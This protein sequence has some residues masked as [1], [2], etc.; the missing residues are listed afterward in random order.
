VGHG[1]ARR[2]TAGGG[3]KE[4][5]TEKR[6]R[7]LRR[8]LATYVLL[9]LLSAAALFGIFVLGPALVGAAEQSAAQEALVLEWD[10]RLTELNVTHTAAAD[11]SAGCWRLISARYESPEESGGLH[12][13]FLI[14]LDEQGNQLAGQPWTVA[15]PEGSVALQTKPAPDWADFPMYASYAPDRGEAG[16]YRAFVGTDEAR[17]DIVA[18]MG[19]PLK[20]HV[21]F[22]L[23][24]RWTVDVGPSPTP[25]STTTP[26]PVPEM[27]LRW[28]LPVTI[29]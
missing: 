23:V 4:H 10:P 19:L 17:S 18:G 21:N 27:P 15:W 9:I 1:V 11:C 22:R 12:H 3:V 8:E 2:E 25:S 7:K 28:H 14:A 29:K 13:I 26:G 20:H 16:S 24:F 5:D 6:V